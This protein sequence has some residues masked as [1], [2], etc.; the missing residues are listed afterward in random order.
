MC[1]RIALILLITLLFG[2]SIATAEDYL[3]IHTSDGETFFNLADIDSITFTEGD[4]LHPGEERDLPLTDDIN[5]TM[6][7]IPAGDFEMGSPDDEDGRNGFEGP[8]HDVSIENGFWMGKYEVTQA[9]WEA[10]TGENPARNYGVGDNHPVYYVSWNDIHYDFLE[11]LDDGFRLPSEAEWEYACRAGTTMRFYWGDDPDYE[12][13]DDYA[14]YRDNDTVGTAEVG[15]KRPNAWGLYNMSGNVHEWC[16]DWYHANY[17]GAP[18]DG[19]P[20]VAGGGEYRVLRGGS[21][22]SIEVNCRSAMRWGGT[23]SASLSIAGFR[24]V[25]AP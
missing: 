16:E 1:I 11:Q 2:I 18:N 6:V 15:T 24:L 17:N 25:Y 7:W 14:V 5:V 20:W 8:V 21:W 4:S 3:I 19:S 9:Q 23:P 13:I 10:V 22:D 12:D